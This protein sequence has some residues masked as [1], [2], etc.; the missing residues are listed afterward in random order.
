[1]ALLIAVI[2]N[3]VQSNSIEDTTIDIR[4]KVE[5][6][7]KDLLEIQA[8]LKSGVAVSGGLAV[9]GTS[10]SGLTIENP[11]APG[12]LLSIDPTPLMA[13]GAKKGGTLNIPAGSDFKGWNFLVENSTDVAAVE[14]IFLHAML[15]RRSYAD[16]D[17]WHGDLAKS[18]TVS[19]DKKTYHVKLRE[20]VKWHKP[21]VEL[22]NPR[23]EW[24]DK[25]HEV[26][27]DDFKFFFEMLLDDKVQGAASKRGYYKDDFDRIEILG[28]HEFKLHWN[29][30]TYQSKAYSLEIYPMP[31]WLYGFD[32]DGNE[33]P[34]V[35]VAVKFNSHWYNDRGI[36]VGPYRFVEAKPGEYVK[37]ERF[38][39]YFGGRTAID[40]INIFVVKD[41][42]R[43]ILM[44]KKG[45]LDFFSMSPTQYRKEVQEG[46]ENSPFRNGDFVLTKFLR[47]AY[48]YVGWNLK[49]DLFKDKR[50]RRAMTHGFDRKRIVEEVWVGLGKVVTGGFF[51]DSPAYDKSIEPYPF[52]LEKAKALL[53]EA[54]WIDTNKDGVRDKVIGGEKKKFQFRLF[55]YN[56]SPEYK[57]MADI[58]KEDLLKIGV[59]MKVTPLDWPIMQKKMED[60]DFEAYT[61]GWGLD[62]EPDPH[63]LWHSSQA[64]APKASNFI[65][66]KNKEADEI[67]ETARKTFDPAEREK[68][69]HRF[70]AIMHEEQPYTFFS[71]PITLFWTGPRYEAF[72]IQKP[73]P[74]A[75]HRLG[76]IDDS[77]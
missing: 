39:D 19:P 71:V 63:Q 14:Q 77:K 50:V 74:H 75:L 66:F 26:T 7:Q 8:Q 72:Q 21:A 44:F 64:D 34:K 3:I 57:T 36:G 12:Q 24:L 59:V 76:W 28:P 46:E 32:E 69:F 31:R 20:G 27:S 13:E 11:D 4:Q 5:Q 42:E 52:D 17:K 10:G 45:E 43:R 16:P 30:K 56:N 73:R 40:K 15:A 41:N 68:L 25:E 62:W 70:H 48:R 51:Y 23:Y 9:L 33:Y 1:L 54:G 22:S 47:L 18:I 55:I 49:S 38:T 35:I 29:K 6:N 60:K 53:D 67:I 61:G 2:I 37:L 58:Y 65:S